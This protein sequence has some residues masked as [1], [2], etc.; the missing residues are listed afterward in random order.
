MFE[1]G[2]G[3]ALIPSRTPAL[4]PWLASA[5]PPEAASR[6]DLLGL[7]DLVE[8][9]ELDPDQA[10]H[11]RADHRVRD[12]PE[13]VEVGD[14]VGDELDRVHHPGP[15]QDRV[16]HQRLRHL[17]EPGPPQQVQQHDGAVGV[18]PGRVAGADHRRHEVHGRRSLWT[19]GHPRNPRR[20]RSAS[21]E[22]VAQ[23]DDDPRRNDA[24]HLQKGPGAGRDRHAGAGRDGERR[25]R[26]QWQSAM[27]RPR[28]TTRSTL[29]SSAPR[30][31]RRSARSRSVSST[32]S[33][34]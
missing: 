8:L 23:I 18:D 4:I 17:A 28:V 5:V 7:A 3:E 32:A 14:L 34:R 24:E 16:P 26:W 2:S 20:R 33:L 19:S 15:D 21:T 27:A 6:D 30:R 9:G 12:V 1:N 11:R 25:A 10:R 22:R 13:V 31:R 29:P